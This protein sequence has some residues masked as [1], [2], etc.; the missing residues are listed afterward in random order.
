M[1]RTRRYPSF[2]IPV[3]RI[4]ELEILQWTL[5]WAGNG[6]HFKSAETGQYLAPAGTASDGTKIIVQS[7]PFLWHIWPDTADPT[8]HR[9][10][11]ITPVFFYLF[12]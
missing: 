4:P 10:D 11:T 8:Y 1:A 7:T 9:C 2:R 3:L 5:E 6:W 12:L